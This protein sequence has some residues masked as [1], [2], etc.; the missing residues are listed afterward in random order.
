M[1]N[2]VDFNEGGW[3]ISVDF[4]GYQL[5]CYTQNPYDLSFFSYGYSC[6][7][8]R[9]KMTCFSDMSEHACLLADHF[10]VSQVLEST[11]PF[12]LVAHLNTCS[13]RMNLYYNWPALNWRWDWI[14]CSPS[15]LFHLEWDPN[16]HGS[17][18]WYW[19]RVCPKGIDLLYF[20]PM[21]EKKSVFIGLPNA[22]SY[23]HMQRFQLALNSSFD[24]LY[25]WLEGTSTDSHPDWTFWKQYTPHQIFG[26]GVAESI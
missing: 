11:S 7:E 24:Q 2:I 17:R 8:R 22:F 6:W 26:R 21:F 20:G 18:D 9:Q 12:Q 13:Y 14:F 16:L 25:Q 10:S 1:L 23:F 4:L 15:P 5:D 3:W 19:V